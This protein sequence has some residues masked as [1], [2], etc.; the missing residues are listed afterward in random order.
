MENRHLYF[1]IID[2]EQKVH[3]GGGIHDEQI[4]LFYL[5]LEE[6]KDFIYDESKAKTPGLMFAFYWFFENSDKL[7]C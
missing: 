2:D 5:P 1:A 7:G 3:D 6:A 4:E